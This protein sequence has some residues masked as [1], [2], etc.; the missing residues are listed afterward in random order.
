MYVT[1]NGDFFDWPFIETRAAKLGMDM[2]QEIGFKMD[3]KTHECLSRRVQPHLERE[4][5]MRPCCPPFSAGPT[6]RMFKA[7]AAACSLFASL[8]RHMVTWQTMG[9]DGWAASAVPAHGTESA[10]D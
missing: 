5:H 1:Y 10:A 8:Q 9:I 7:S 2:Q 3:A 4:H 6:S